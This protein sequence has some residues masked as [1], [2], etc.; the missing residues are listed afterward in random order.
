M[1]NSYISNHCYWMQLLSVQQFYWKFSISDYF[2]IVLNIYKWRLKYLLFFFW[3]LKIRTLQEMLFRIFKNISEQC[4]RRCF[5]QYIIPFCSWCLLLYF[6]NFCSFV[7]VIYTIR[8]LKR[9]LKSLKQIIGDLTLRKMIWLISTR[10]T[11][12]IWTGNEAFWWAIRHF[13]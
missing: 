13:L 4:T 2:N 9:I 11:R 6:F 7:I 1:L 5:F 3:L 12:V 8:S 10:S